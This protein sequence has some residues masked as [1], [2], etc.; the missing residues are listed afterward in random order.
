MPKQ[1]FFKLNEEKKQAIMTSAFTEFE[2][3]PFDEASINRIIKQAKISRGSFYLYFED[4]EDVYHYLMEQ[5]LTLPFY[6]QLDQVMTGKKAN[7]FD[8]TGQ[9]FVILATI[10][11]ERTLFWQQILQ[12]STA[13]QLGELFCFERHDKEL[14]EQYHLSQDHLRFK[15]VPE[16]KMLRYTLRSLLYHYLLLVCEGEDIESVRSLLLKHMATFKI[17]WQ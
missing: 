3:Y 1:A 14:F 4:K 16:Q 7:I 12:H 13:Q 2:R 10:M 11:K 5:L 8:F 17:G 6:Q 15:A 9:C